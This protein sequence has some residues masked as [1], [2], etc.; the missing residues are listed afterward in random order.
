[1][2]TLI[3]AAISGLDYYL[4]QARMPSYVKLEQEIL[5]GP[6]ERSVGVRNLYS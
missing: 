1:M 4:R 3:Y 2:V 6:I 5:Y